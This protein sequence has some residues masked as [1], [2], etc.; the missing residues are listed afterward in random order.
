MLYLRGV[1]HRGR[2]SSKPVPVQLPAWLFL[3][4]VGLSL[5][6]VDQALPVDGNQ[7]SKALGAI[8]GNLVLGALFPVH[9][10]PSATQ[11]QTRTCG[12]VREQYGIQRVEAAFHTIDQINRN[13][14]ILPNITL[15]IEVRDSCWYVIL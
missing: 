1:R 15:G 5:V 8:P 11:A 9:H 12:E 3:W 13:A 10:A 14:D 2:T 6:V 7:Y 4:F